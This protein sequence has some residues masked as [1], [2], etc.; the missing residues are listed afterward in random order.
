MADELTFKDIYLAVENL[1]KD[2]SAG[3]LEVEKKVEKY[4]DS[5]VKFEEGK[6]SDLIQRVTI[7]EKDREAL[8]K[9]DTSQEKLAEKRK[10]WMWG[11]FE[12]IL[13]ILIGFIFT[14]IGLVLSKLGI[15]N[16]K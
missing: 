8:V 16:L 5:F 15:L 3:L 11:A 4:H 10:E 14:V 7:L 2:F 12:K 13:F 9:V 1:R 6:V